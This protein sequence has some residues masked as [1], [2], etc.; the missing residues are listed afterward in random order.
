MRRLSTQ[1]FFH[2][3]F[4]H[5]APNPLKFKWTY[6]FPIRFYSEFFLCPPTKLVTHSCFIFL[7]IK[8]K[9]YLKFP[10]WIH[11]W[12]KEELNLVCQMYLSTKKSFFLQHPW[13]CLVKCR[14]QINRSFFPY[15]KLVIWAPKAGEIPCFVTETLIWR[16]KRRSMVGT[17]WAWKF[18]S[19]CFGVRHVFLVLQYNLCLFPNLEKNLIYFYVHQLSTYV[20]VAE[21]G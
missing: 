6:N 4:L 10:N 3:T 19:E 5:L 12:L 21:M 2:L 18:S 11:L 8:V 13:Q 14:Y 15:L 9:D 7:S 1:F 16:N 20:W 17:Y